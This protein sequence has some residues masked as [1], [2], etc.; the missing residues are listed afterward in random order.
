MTT[1]VLVAAVAAVAAVW[2]RQRDAAHRAVWLGLG[3]YAGVSLASL[4][5]LHKV[6]AVLARLVLTL[7]TL[8]LIQ[9]AAAILAVSGSGLAGR[10]RQA[11]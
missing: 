4:L 3:I 9:L 10:W 1:L 6:D 11:R 5:S 8:Q 7:S 2:I